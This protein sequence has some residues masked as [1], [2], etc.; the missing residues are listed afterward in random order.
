MAMIPVIAPT[1]AAISN[2]SARFMAADGELVVTA[3][4]LAGAETV[5]PY[6]GGP[7]GA[8]TQVSDASGFT[9]LTATKPQMTLPG[10][11]HYA[12]DKSSSGANVGVDVAM[13]YNSK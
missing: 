12:F 1:T 8:W 2:K 6:V 11:F 5:T 7:N 13:S 9:T 10:G 3:S 4:G